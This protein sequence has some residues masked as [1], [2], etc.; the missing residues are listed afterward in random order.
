[1]EVKET[2][3]EYWIIIDG[4]QQNSHLSLEKRDSVLLLYLS[5]VQLNFG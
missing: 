3:K 1:M 2:F 4:F 5:S